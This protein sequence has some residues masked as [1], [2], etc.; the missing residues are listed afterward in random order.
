M[1]TL[2]T[3]G[4]ALASVVLAA[5]V[6]GCGL[7]LGL[8]E[9]TEGKGSG[10]AG[11]GTASSTGGAAESCMNGTK[12]SNETDK[13]C[14]GVCSPCIDGKGCDN[15]SDCESRVCSPGGA[16]SAPTCSDS[17]KNGTETDVDC[18]S[19]CPRCVDGRAC[20]VG[21]DCASGLCADRICT[22]IACGDGTKNG[23]ETDVDCGGGSCPGCA[24]AKACGVSTDCASGI[25]KTNT[26][27][28]NHLWSKRFGDADTQVATRVAVD[29]SGNVVVLG[30]FSGTVNFGGGPLTNPCVP[31]PLDPYSCI[32]DYFLVRF[33]NTG[34]HLWS[35]RFYNDNDN[36]SNYDIDFSLDSANNIYIA[37]H[38]TGEFNFGGGAL[39]DPT[40]CTQGCNVDTAVVKLDSSGKYLWGKRFAMD[41]DQYVRAV[42][43]STS[44]GVAI[45]GDF[46]KS[47]N[48]GGTTLTS[49][50]SLDV[51]VAMLSSSGAHVWS[52]S[53]GDA[54]FFEQSGR[55]IAVDAAGNTLLAG[56]YSSGINFGGGNLPTTGGSDLFLAKLNATGGHVWSK[57]FGD[58]QDQFSYSDT[59]RI[60]VDPSGNTLFVGQLR[61][62][63]NFGGGALSSVTGK[64]I[65]V[66]KF[67][68]A[69]APL[70]S[71]KFGDTLGVATTTVY[72]VAAD[73]ANGVILT[74]VSDGSVNFGGEPL[75]GG[76]LVKLDAAGGHV[77]SKAFGG[78]SVAADGT[79]AIVLAGRFVGTQD[80]G[81]G[82][83]TSAGSFD[84]AVAKL[85]NP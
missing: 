72:D 71:K 12:D 48:F 1:K 23:A 20:V 25:C 30:A 36:L 28:Q 44:S 22:K 78:H 26:C 46:S 83:L 51:F 38:G 56:A 62:S 57:H 42:A 24:P 82:P 60:A 21:M 66:A 74:G 13:D 81:G 11:G 16:C 32:D 40:P 35:K 39:F 49:Q 54:S 17:T 58:V 10:G 55:A 37:T 18:G 70:W 59:M 75:A 63:V 34:K 47:V 61:S 31:D 65:F 67:D 9:F 77:W 33:D 14:G 76:F 29:S 85:V 19:S 79:Q 80:F 7:I 50:G 8:D 6:S 41:G 27:L 52:K 73:G 2:R 43:G 84:V 15:A 53:F 68:P 3:S 5:G 64:D 45:V 4:L 69:G